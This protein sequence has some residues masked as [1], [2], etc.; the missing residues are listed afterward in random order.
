MWTCD[1][2][3]FHWHNVFARVTDPKPVTPLS[4]K[5][6]FGNEEGCSLCESTNASLQHILS[7]CKTAPTQGSYTWPDFEE[8]GWNI[9][10]PSC[11]WL[12][13]H[14][15]HQAWREHQRHQ[16]ARLIKTP[17]SRQ[18]MK[19]EGRPR[20]CCQ[21]RSSHHHKRKMMKYSELAAECREAGLTSSTCPAEVDCRGVINTTATSGHRW[22]RGE[23]PTRDLRAE[24][25]SFRL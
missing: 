1:Y 12:T 20:Y 4:A 25:S 9:Q 14:P 23:A 21:D 6:W 8:A 7:G 3:I 24:M 13:F 11:S 2:C 22:N 17:F 16:F 5:R 15:V 10:Q 19:H 18:G